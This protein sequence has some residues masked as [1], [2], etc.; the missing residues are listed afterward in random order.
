M[1]HPTPLAA[2]E[3][4]VGCVTEDD[5]KY[6]GQALR[7]LQSIRWF[8]GELSRSRVLV[9]AVER[10]D[11]RAR[12]ALEALGAEIRIV[13]RF[14]RRNGSANR[15]QLFAEVWDGPEE[16]LLSL[17][18]DTLVVRDPLPLLRRGVFQA[19]V[20]PQPTVTHEVF[21]RVFAAMGVDLPERSYTTG[22]TG[23]PTIPYFNAGVIAATKDVVDRLIPPWRHYNA[24]L[25]DELWLV[26]P[27]TTHVDQAALALALA[28]SG[29]PVA[30]AP[31]ELNYQLNMAYLPPP[32]GYA[33][34]DPFIIHYHH[35]IDG[36]GFL[37]PCQFPRAQ[38]RI[39]AF[40]DRLR[41][42]RSRSMHRRERVP[43][44]ASSSRQIAV[45][46]MHRSGTS[47]V[48]RLLTAMGCYAGEDHELPPPDVYNPAGYWE[49]RDVVAL[50][51]EVLAALDTTWLDPA[52]AD[53]DAL[54][55]EGRHAFVERARAI[56]RGFDAH[57]SWMMKDPRLSILFPLWREALHSPVCILVW[58]EPG[59]VA[60][61]IA[62]RDDLPVAVGL[63]LW[64]E[65]TRAMLGST[66]G[67]P[68][69]LVSYDDFV[70]DPI[71]SASRLHGEL[72]AA[73][74]T[75]LRLPLDAEIRLI[76]EPSF[77]RHAGHG[78]VPLNAGQSE[79][80]DA[81]RS[82]AALAWHTITPADRDTRELLSA[83]SRHQHS[84]MCRS[85]A[86]AREL[87]QLLAAV[88]DSRSWRIGFA[89]T[90]LWRRIVPSNLPTARERWM[91]LRKP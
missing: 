19:K 85:A 63:A 66:A 49:H 15:L 90:R 62:E 23:T 7:L 48:A 26:E 76:V 72:A 51:E 22:Y 75:N 83:F 17:D 29:V 87:D 31:P 81:L 78:G 39:D 40:N 16:M 25:A 21:E 8:G 1:P 64:E 43:A 41:Q 35:L 46:G 47:L 6:L 61:S 89:I 65:Y 91:R 14:D 67:L 34:L 70:S 27:C 38:E 82:G 5:P 11:A 54:P 45:V 73:G 50:N 68:R 12:R 55:E 52:R 18:C 3:V 88:F 2:S 9:C 77:N 58:R 37:L 32:P 4:V 59:A 10:I 57:G 20:A 86:E 33:D 36:D 69:V 44:T 24:R 79:L 84:H 71:G 13:P 42:E 60:R 74:A 28:V 30:A 56:A 80:R 53:I